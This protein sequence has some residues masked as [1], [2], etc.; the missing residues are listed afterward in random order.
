MGNEKNLI[1]NSARTPSERRENA[2]KAGLASG[3]ARRKKA[4]LK[5]AF[6]IILQADVANPSVKKQLEDMG[7]ESTNEM[8][9]AMVIFQKA[10]KGNIKAFE[11]IAKL[12]N[13]ETKDSLDRKEQRRR[14]ESIELANEQKRVALSEGRPDSEEEEVTGFIFDRNREE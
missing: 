6:E 10:L 13:L 14:V 2:R 9:L 8:A 1:P 7:F 4:D 11:Q 5:K 3:R 12:T